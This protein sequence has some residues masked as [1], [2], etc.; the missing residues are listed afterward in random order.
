VHKQYKHGAIIFIQTMPETNQNMT[1]PIS[2]ITQH[3]NETTPILI[4]PKPKLG[5]LS[6]ASYLFGNVVGS[7]IFVS[8]T[9]ILQQSNS[10]GACIAVIYK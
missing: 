5:L 6:S 9:F 10:V 4:K 7:G 3:V 1:S 8:P 2:T